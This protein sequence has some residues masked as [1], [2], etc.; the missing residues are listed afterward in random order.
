M[1]QIADG[2]R[3]ERLKMACIDLLDANREMFFSK[4]KKECWLKFTKENAPL[5]AEIATKL[6]EMPFNQISSDLA[7]N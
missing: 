2:H 7:Q 6:F 3:A 1:V 5:A 4:D